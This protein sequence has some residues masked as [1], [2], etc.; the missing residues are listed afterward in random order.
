MR[1]V[2]GEM[3]A[4][5]LVGLR[6]PRIVLA[7]DL[8]F[9]R[10]AAAAGINPLQ[11]VELKTYDWRL[12]ATARPSTARQ[13][14]ALVEIDE[15]SLRNLEPNAGRWPWPRVI[16]AELLDY[17]ARAPAKVIV[18][19]VNFAEAGYRD[20]VSSSARSVMTGAES[21]QALV[22]V[23]RNRRQRD[24]ARRRDLRSRRRHECLRS[25][26]GLHAD[27]PGIIERP[28]HFSSRFQRWPPR[29]G[30]RAQP[31]R[32][33]SGWR[34]FGTRCRSCAPAIASCRRSGWPPRC[35]RRAFRPGRRRPR[36]RGAD[37]SAIA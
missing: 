32:A 36:R 9:T 14:I 19:D 11:T 17:L 20:S 18:Y 34:R 23:G 33:R 7:A 6:P 22:D 10:S 12:T 26:S 16:H 30:S 13:D 4:G 37:G 8:L 35:A 21:D 2:R 1:K 25:G 28:R 3:L 15:Y 31:V 24:P 27:A 29:P 5:V